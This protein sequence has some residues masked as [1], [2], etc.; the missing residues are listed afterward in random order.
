MNL[1]DKPIA[2]A[3]KSWAVRAAAILGVITAIV[4]MLNADS[5]PAWVSVFHPADIKAT[6]D[7]LLPYITPAAVALGRM[8]QQ[9]SIS[10]P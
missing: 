6:W 7:W 10:G 5:A 9:D 2:T 3:L 8:V 1:I 4:K